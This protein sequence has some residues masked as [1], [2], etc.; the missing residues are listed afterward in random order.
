MCYILQRRKTKPQYEKAIYIYLKKLIHGI[1][2]LYCKQLFTVTI[3][4]WLY[5]M[6]INKGNLSKMS[7]SYIDHLGFLVNNRILQFRSSCDY[8]IAENLTIWI[9]E[10]VNWSIESH[11]AETNNLLLWKSSDMARPSD[12]KAF[13]HNPTDDSIVSLPN[14]TDANIKYLN[15]WS[16]SYYYS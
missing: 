5:M 6:I 3:K 11:Y 7:E 15:E 1:F 9:W 2:T 13:S 4:K 8:Q 16:L 10:N 14:W 12:L